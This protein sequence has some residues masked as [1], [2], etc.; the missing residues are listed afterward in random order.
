DAHE[1]QFYEFQTNVNAS[2]EVPAD[3]TERKKWLAKRRTPVV[4]PE[5]T[6]VYQK[7]YGADKKASY[8]EAFEIC[9]YGAQPDES[10]IRQLFP[11][12]PSK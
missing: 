7:W 12:L 10:R 2:V 3:K 6:A 9:E 11:M 4:T 1:S 5:V 8:F